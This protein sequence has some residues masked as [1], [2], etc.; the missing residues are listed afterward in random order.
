M[1]KVAHSSKD[2]VHPSATPP[3]QR[4]VVPAGSD[5]LQAP[6][7]VPPSQIQKLVQGLAICIHTVCFV[8]C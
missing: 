1:L 3:S 6:R 2:L 7:K 4:N 8:G 5:S